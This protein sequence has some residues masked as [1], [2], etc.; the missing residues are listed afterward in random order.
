MYNVS[1][2]QC[3]VLSFHGA[4]PVKHGKTGLYYK[5]RHFWVIYGHLLEIRLWEGSVSPW[6]PNMG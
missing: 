2:H 6:G 1:L 5:N 4:P 3:Q